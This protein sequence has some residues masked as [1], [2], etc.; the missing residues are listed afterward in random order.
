MAPA[1]LYL[2]QPQREQ[3]AEHDRDHIAPDA[4]ALGGDRPLAQVGLEEQAPAVRGA[5]AEID[6][7]QRPAAL[8][9]A[10][11][12]AAEVA[13][14]G[15]HAGAAEQLTLVGLEREALADQ[16]RLVGVD[17]PPLLVPQLHPDDRAS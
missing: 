9:E 16:A 12:R 4:A 6:L 10:V 15:A 17:D 5:Q 14:V 7:T 13:H 8:L 2:H 3:D 1:E 11:L